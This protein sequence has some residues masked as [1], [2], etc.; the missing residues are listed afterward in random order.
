MTETYFTITNEA[1]SEFSD[2]GSKFLGYTF[3]IGSVEEGKAK[4]HGVKKEHPKASHHCFA[5]RIGQLAEIHRVSDDG[6]PSGS[7]GR[8]ILNQ[9]QSLELTNAMVVVVRYFGGTMLGIPGLINA[10]K[11][12]AADALNKAGKLEK[13]IEV[14]V[15]V[16]CDYTVM[17]D[18]MQV[19]R[20]H[21][22]SILEREQMLFCRFIAGVPVGSRDIFEKRIRDIRG[23]E[24]KQVELP[25]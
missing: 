12:A 10:Y 21:N 24:V 23:A 1:R 4:L 3:P 15:E 20:Q 25:G 2:R 18:V 16:T 22:V 17:N 7:A 5:W 13:N 8:P 19:F 9:L 11:T 6:E 14:N